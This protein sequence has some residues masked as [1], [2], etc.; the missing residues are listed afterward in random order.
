MRGWKRPKV[1]DNLV[2]ISGGLNKKMFA[3]KTMPITMGCV[4]F[5]FVALDKNADWL[6]KGVG[7]G[8]CRKGELKYV[9]VFDAIRLKFCGPEDDNEPAVAAKSAVAEDE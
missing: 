1:S 3:V 4:A 9:N 2:A 5:R 8:Q 6:L 7:G